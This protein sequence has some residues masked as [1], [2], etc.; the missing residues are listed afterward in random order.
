MALVGQHVR[1]LV[2]RLF[3]DNKANGE[4]VQI[5]FMF[6]AAALVAAAFFVRLA[7][8]VPECPL[9]RTLNHGLNAR[10]PSVTLGEAMQKVKGAMWRGGPVVEG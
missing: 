5:V 1:T 10:H 6:R 2:Y 8:D 4:N 3:V 7:H 9:A